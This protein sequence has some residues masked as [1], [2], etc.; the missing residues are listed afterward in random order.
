MAQGTNKTQLLVRSQ[1]PEFIA[2]DYPKFVEF[3]KA[4]YTFVS[5][6][7]NI[8]VESLRDADNTSSSLL[9]FLRREL[10]KNFP[11]ALINERKLINTIREVYSR[12]GNLDSIKL[13]FKLFFNDSI[14]IRQPGTQI[15]RASDGKWFQYNV[16]TLSQINWEKV[17]ADI[18]RAAVQIQPYKGLFDTLSGGFKIGDVN[19]SGTVTSDD[20]LAINK[21]SLNPE[22]VT[23]TQKTHIEQT[24]IPALVGNPSF[25]DYIYSDLD[26]SDIVPEVSR[27][28]IEN[29]FGRFTPTVSFIEVEA[30]KRIRVFFKS[31]SK[32]QVVR[33]QQISITGEDGTVIFTGVHNTSTQNLRVEKPG[34]NW[35]RGQVI[36]IPGSVKN[37][38]ARV[39]ETDSQGGL[40]RVEILE[41][42]FSHDENLAIVISPYP[43]KP[44]DQATYDVTTTVTA[45]N[46]LTGVPTAYS[47]LVTMDDYTQGV[48]EG[49]YGEKNA[50]DYAALS[51]A[52]L[53]AAQGNEP[54]KTLFD[55]VQ[56][57][58]KIGDI[59]QTGTVTTSD[60][61]LVSK[62]AANPDNVTTQQKT[63]IETILLPTLKSLIE[64]INPA[65]PPAYAGVL[66][67][68]INPFASVISVST[69][70]TNSVSYN[71]S[72]LTFEEWVDSRAVLFF[73]RADVIKTKGYYLN[74]DSQI[75][76]DESRL[77][78][79]YFYQLFSYLIE[80]TKSEKEVS[81]ILNQF[82]PAGMKYF[83]QL[84]KQNFY[85][86]RDILESYR[87][88]STDV[89]FLR[90]IYTGTVEV[91]TK[92]ATRNL[93][94]EVLFSYVDTISKEF[95]KALSDAIDTPVEEIA[96]DAI[97]NI[98]GDIFVPSDADPL[99]NFTKNS[100][101]DTLPVS[102]ADP[103]KNAV[104]AAPDDSAAPIDVG[105]KDFAKQAVGDSTTS[106][107]SN[108]K[109]FTK[110]SIDATPATD[111]DPTRNFTKA[112]TDIQLAEDSA[113]TKTAVKQAT[114]DSATPADA[115]ALKDSV[116]AATDTLTS[117]D[118][119]QKTFDKLATPDAVTY[120]DQIG[121][122]AA[123]KTASD[124]VPPAD[125]T[126]LLAFVKNNLDSSIPNDATYDK[127][128][129]K[130]A[131]E[132]TATLNEGSFISID[133]EG[134]SDTNDYV[135]SSEDYSQ[136][137][138]T[139]Y[140]G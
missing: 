41:Y 75:S 8:K 51:D 135:A 26:V 36:T 88:I 73:D 123:T 2:N 76:N 117:T 120:S 96:K 53:Q 113:P 11:S 68:I 93:V 46:P 83:F 91:A 139:T 43:V 27:L 136:L 7:Y 84:N 33:G 94:E 82:H 131:V 37:T 128:V 59:N 130:Y 103:T 38:I 61:I 44:S 39:V 115:N 69:T 105:V 30:N 110:N 116:K 23:P 133:T 54:E 10:L 109:D 95:T 24:L 55:I 48:T 52:I 80:T 19:R 40:V 31:Y 106:S 111:A 118:A 66:Y 87:S 34:K 70:E 86:I 49:I 79:N 119:A 22:N 67:S 28:V 29:K 50:I 6:N 81:Q 125:Q 77:Q 20:A 64:T 21:Y 65:S 47:H 71:F 15:L 137:N 122:K 25:N 16:V 121:E 129:T 101:D 12:K 3:L 4:Y 100:T 104:K 13:L 132:E 92:V 97:K 89:V 124:T 60:S 114:D 102:D 78:D 58:W 107:D 32:L 85:S 140:I 62:Y 90:E 74:D 108:L 134:F 18:L 112:S 9:V 98:V 35:Q 17:S 63:H 45:V 126:P 1:L 57:G 72:E 127:I 56:S 42:G 138:L 5:N 14:I 99:K